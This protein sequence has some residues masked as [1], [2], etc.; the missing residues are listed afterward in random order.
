[1]KVIFT[2]PGEIDPLLIHSFGVNVK[3]GDNPIGYFGTGL[4]Y[5]LAVLIRTGQ[6]VTIY[7][8]ETVYTVGKV[9]KTI[10]DKTFEFITLND[11]PLG[12]TTDLGKNWELWMAYRELY[13]N[14]L[15]EGG[16][17]TTDTFF[18]GG[19]ATF[20]NVV[21]EGDAFFEVHSNRS[22][23]FLEGEPYIKFGGVH[24][25]KNP[26]TTLFYR[27]ICVGQ[28]PQPSLYTYNILTQTALTEDRT[29]KDV[30]TASFRLVAELR[31]YD[32]EELLEKILTAE[33]GTW[34]NSFDFD[35][36]ST[37]GKVYLDTIGRLMEYNS[38]NLND[39]AK[40]DYK[41]HRLDSREPVEIELDAFESSMLAECI[42]FCCAFKFPVTEYPIKC[43]ESLGPGV[44]GQARSGTIYITRST[45]D[46]GKKHLTETLIE[47]FI[48]LRYQVEDFTREMQEVLLTRLVQAGERLLGK[49]L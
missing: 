11:Q 23:Y 18:A 12:F 33:R 41:R 1:M 7:S 35:Y 47:E 17:V 2:N 14:A 27:G 48:H 5:A 26:S 36:S 38:A 29:V 3:T 21:V 19:I 22:E 13:C 16:E 40:L 42:E 25:H 9:E 31:H 32:D 49:G 44:F 6:R 43:V 45:F 46:R 10:R 37:P 30:Y 28:L 39:T 34:E 15:D 4:K 24:I 8:G 20:T